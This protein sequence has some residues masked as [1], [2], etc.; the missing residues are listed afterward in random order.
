MQRL[1]WTP[2]RLEK[3]V[4]DVYFSSDSL[5]DRV[6]ASTQLT[7]AKMENRC[8]GGSLATND[9]QRNRGRDHGAMGLGAREPIGRME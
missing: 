9:R 3:K 4:L 2:I 7:F 1:F 8:R 6:E 5:M